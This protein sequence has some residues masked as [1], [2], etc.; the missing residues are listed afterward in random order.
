MVIKK[1]INILKVKQRTI[2]QEIIGGN[3]DKVS[4]CTQNAWI[5]PHNH[6]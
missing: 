6:I 2:A 4:D 3:L 5:N 1:L